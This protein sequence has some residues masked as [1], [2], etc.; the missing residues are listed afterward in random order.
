MILWRSDGNY[1]KNHSKTTGTRSKI[2]NEIVF[3]DNHLLTLHEKC[4]YMYITIKKDMVMQL[5][6]T[7]LTF[8]IHGCFISK[9][10]IIHYPSPECS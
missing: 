6:F 2:F 3:K 9:R 1:T 5:N 7:H 10:V 8:E 4:I